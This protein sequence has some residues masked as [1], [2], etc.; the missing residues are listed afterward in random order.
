MLWKISHYP[1]PSNPSTWDNGRDC[2][3]LSNS[4][5]PHYFNPKGNDLK[6]QKIMAYLMS[7]I[8]ISGELGFLIQ[9]HDYGEKFTQKFEINPPSRYENLFKNANENHKFWSYLATC[10]DTFEM[11]VKL[12]LVP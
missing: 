11:K 5:V 6:P 8:D 12:V 1:Y 3:A 4:L 9:R 7:G 10:H 2:I